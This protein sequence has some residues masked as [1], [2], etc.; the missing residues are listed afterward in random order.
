MVTPNLSYEL[1][2][3]SLYLQPPSPLGFFFY[4]RRSHHPRWEHLLPPSFAIVIIVNRS[5]Q[6]SWQNKKRR[7]FHRSQF[8]IRLRNEDCSMN[9]NLRKMKAEASKVEF[10]FECWNA[11]FR[12]FKFLEK[13]RP[14]LTRHRTNQ[15]GIP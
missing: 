9:G 1:R 13:D 11:W 8:L 14:S 10:E 3:N 2:Q 6:M 4:L 7:R 12:F 15:G 5:R